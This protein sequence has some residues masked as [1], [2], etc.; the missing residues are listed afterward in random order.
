MTFGLSG[1]CVLRSR[2]KS[3]VKLN[4]SEINNS[5]GFANFFGPALG[6]HPLHH[7]LVFFALRGRENCHR[8]LVHGPFQGHHFGVPLSGS[9]RR[10]SVD[11]FV[12]RPRS[13]Y[14]RHYPGFLGFGEI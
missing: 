14:N 11:A 12:L 1:A 2:R 7:A 5:G 3:D 8:F 10:I 4:D 13:I 6:A 9:Q